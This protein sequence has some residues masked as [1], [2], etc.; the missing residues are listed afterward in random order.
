[1]TATSIP[2]EYWDP[3]RGRYKSHA[4]FGTV[5]HHHISDYS[6][7]ETCDLMIVECKDGRWYIEDNWGGD[8]KGA[9]DVFQPH[10]KGSY[11]TFFNTLEE[12]NLR[13]AEI[14][15]SITGA[16]VADLLLED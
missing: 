14:V 3:S 15:S 10:T 7:D 2:E 16:N 6:G 12:C 1:M 11:P 5:N 8:A 13:A 4:Y 9:K